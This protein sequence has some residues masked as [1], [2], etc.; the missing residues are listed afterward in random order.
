MIRC[1]RGLGRAQKWKQL[2]QRREQLRQ[3]RWQLWREQHREPQQGLVR[4]WQGWPLRLQADSLGAQWAGCWQAPAQEVGR[5][6]QAGRA[7]QYGLQIQ[8][9]LQQ[10]SCL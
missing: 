10:R 6:R 9:L 4:V 7:E 1:S 3:R 5:D 8:A 2:L